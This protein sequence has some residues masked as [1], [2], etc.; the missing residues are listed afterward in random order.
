MDKGPF[1][2]EHPLFSLVRE[3]EQAKGCLG[4]TYETGDCYAG[5]YFKTMEE[6]TTFHDACNKHVGWSI[7]S[8]PEWLDQYSDSNPFTK[9]VACVSPLPK[10]IADRNDKYGGDAMVGAL[11]ACVDAGVEVRL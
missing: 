3:M 10:V 6:A 8:K 4:F 7:I 1:V 5:I 11:M 9:A 2:K